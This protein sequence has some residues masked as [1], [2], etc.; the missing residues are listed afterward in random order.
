[1]PTASL[2]KAAQAWWSSRY[3]SERMTHGRF[4]S[5][6]SGISRTSVRRESQEDGRWRSTDQSKCI[7]PRRAVV[8]S[9]PAGTGSASAMAL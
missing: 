5:S 8:S 6:A 7:P 2:E 9:L 3:R 4:R 1:M